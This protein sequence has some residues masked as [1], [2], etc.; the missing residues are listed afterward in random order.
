M[1][2]K[3]I[4]ERLRALADRAAAGHKLTR[5]DALLLRHAAAL[6]EQH[7]VLMDGASERERKA[8]SDACNYGAIVSVVRAE[9]RVLVGHMERHSGADES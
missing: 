3:P 5:P 9:L 6:I 1:K 2:N 8:I 7:E 4:H